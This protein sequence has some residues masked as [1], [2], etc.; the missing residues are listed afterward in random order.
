MLDFDK[1]QAF[2][3]KGLRNGNVKLLDKVQRGFYRACMVYAK[4]RGFISSAKLLDMLSKLIDILTQTR[5]ILA[6]RIGLRRAIQTLSSPTAR[7]FPILVS[8]LSDWG[9]IEYLGF[10]YMNDSP[11]FI[12]PL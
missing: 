4:I 10:T 9:Y 3:I 6:L 11:L 8:W 1:L 7:L 2:W 12:E 5:R